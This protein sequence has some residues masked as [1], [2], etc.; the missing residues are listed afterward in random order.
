MAL[1]TVNQASFAY[2]GRCVAQGLDFQVDTGDYLC[3]VGENGSGKSTL[4]KGILGIKKPFSGEII[5]GGG[6]Q[7]REI[8][9]LPQ[10]TVIQRDF[11]ASVQEVVLSGC[12]S[13][14][15]FRPF[16]TA[17]NKKT[18][19]FTM[20]KLHIDY[21]A[22]HCFRELSEGQKQRVLLARALCATEKLLLLDEPTAGLDPLATVDLYRVID[23]INRE[24][25]TVIMVSHDMSAAV[26]YAKHIL[27]MHYKPLFYGTKEDYVSSSVGKLFTEGG[28]A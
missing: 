23:E 1:I 2:D 25:I 17:K 26:T 8:G 15:E 3:I 4:M 28:I 7:Q 5:F 10:Q 27:H 20:K 16:Y 9:Y 12:L 21:L 6:L 13:D 14:K 11:P 24:G 18:A 22:K 19:M